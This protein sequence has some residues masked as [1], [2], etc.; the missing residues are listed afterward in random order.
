MANETYPMPF[1]TP[2]LCS[3]TTNAYRT[4]AMS[5]KSVCRSVD[6]TAYGMFDTKRVRLRIR[7]FFF[8]EHYCSS[9]I[10]AY[11]WTWASGSS[12]SRSF[13]FPSLD[14]EETLFLSHGNTGPQ[15][16]TIVERAEPDRL[17]LRP[18]PSDFC[19]VR[20]SYH[21]PSIFRRRQL[22]D[23]SLLCRAETGSRKDPQLSRPR[24]LRR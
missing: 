21:A 6:V 10:L 4:G 8:N 13:L 23:E 11:P 2:V 19:H 1:E 5:E 12:S 9:M 7:F 20:I 15:K 22:Q 18:I 16:L 24:F 3:R 14:I 17:I